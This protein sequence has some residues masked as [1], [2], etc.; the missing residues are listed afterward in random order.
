MLDRA[1]RLVYASLHETT[2]A[3]HQGKVGVSLLREAARQQ[4]RRGVCGLS[5]GGQPRE[6][7]GV[8]SEEEGAGMKSDREILAHLHRTR[9]WWWCR[10][11]RNKKNG[12]KSGYLIGTG[13]AEV[14]VPI[15]EL[16]SFVAARKQEHR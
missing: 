12:N 16:A 6:A 1:Y 9:G 14:F 13:E 8:S 5:A 4:G 10:V 7:A 15:S 3:V 2:S 11:R